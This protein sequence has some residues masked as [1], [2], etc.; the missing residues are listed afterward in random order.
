MIDFLVVF[1]AWI[2]QRRYYLGG[3]SKLTMVQSQLLCLQ[4]EK[5]LLC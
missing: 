3:S 1:G 2:T 5:H 4:P